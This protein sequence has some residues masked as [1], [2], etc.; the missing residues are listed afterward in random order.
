[1]AVDLRDVVDVPASAE[2]LG[3]SPSE[4]RRLIRKDQLFARQVAGRWVVP[5]VELRRFASLERPVGRPL[6]QRSAW[7]LLRMIEEPGWRSSSLSPSRHSQLKRLLRDSAPGH[8]AAM[9]RNRARRD[10]YWVHPS[11]ESE[12]L[13]DARVHP[14]GWSALSDLDVGLVAGGD[15]P[16]EMYIRADDLVGA[17]HVFQLEPA[18]AVVNLIAH[19]IDAEVAPDELVW[20]RVMRPASALDLIESGDP[21][22]RSVGQELWGRLV[23][24]ARHG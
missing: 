19:V 6:A 4:A 14:S 15:V 16:I 22:A 7:A 13:A 2:R 1:M 24:S 9:A 23:E 20:E 11:L 17:S 10:L 18:D 3:V 21:R 12:L 8:L 5:E